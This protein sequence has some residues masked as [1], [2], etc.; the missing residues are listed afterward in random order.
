MIKNIFLLLSK[1]MG[2]ISYERLIKGHNN[3][4]K[5]F[6]ANSE[7]KPI[8]FFKTSNEKN[9]LNMVLTLE[10]S[11]Q[12]SFLLGRF[13]WLVPSII[14][15]RVIKFCL[16]TMSSKHFLMVWLRYNSHTRP[17]T[18]LVYNSMVLSIFADMYNYHYNQF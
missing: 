13:Y 8:L 11:A 2:G 6:K 17:F 12:S 5:D 3:F 10:E 18:E 4:S 9:R 15:D 16:S 14:T 7:Q 1:I